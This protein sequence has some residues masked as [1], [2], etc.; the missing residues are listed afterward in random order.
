[1]LR[2]ARYPGLH[3]T[4]RAFSNSVPWLQSCASMA[5]QNSTKEDLKLVF[6][7]ASLELMSSAAWY[8][9]SLWDGNYTFAHPLPL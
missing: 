5:E 3:C 2:V 1:M 9:V 4:A 8:A 7:P 6:E